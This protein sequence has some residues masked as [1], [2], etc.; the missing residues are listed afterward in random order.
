MTCERPLRPG[1]LTAGALIAVIAVMSAGACEPDPDPPPARPAELVAEGTTGRVTLDWADN[2]EEDLTRYEVSRATTSTGTYTVISPSSLTRSTFSDT[3]AP[4]GSIRYYRVVAIDDAGGRSAPAIANGTALGSSFAWGAGAVS[5]ID[6]YEG[7]GAVVG[8]EVLVFGGYYD[9]LFRATATA[10]AYDLATNSWRSLADV[11]ELITHAPA[12]VDG[13]SVWLLGGYV[14]DSPGGATASVWIYDVATDLWRPGPPL[15]ERRGAGAAA[16]VGREL[17]YFGGTDRTQ[18]TE[19]DIDRP[20]HWVLDLDL[21][22]AWTSRAP[23]PNPRNHL[24]AA[25][26]EGKVYA[27]GGQLRD[28][29]SDDNQDD[30]HVYDPATDAW[31]QVANLPRGRGHLMWSTI[32][33]DGHLVAAGGLVGAPVSAPATSSAVTAYDPADDVWFNLAPLPA[34]RK[35]PVFAEVGDRIVLT[36]GATNVPRGET[37]TGT[38]SVTW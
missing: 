6:H 16:V 38:L 27:V 20:D 12:V 4:V 5:P 8:S 28:H 31:A 29:R 14:G 18:D 34:T 19:D 32:A 35:S 17:H 15:P 11:P 22:V 13:N 9:D 30:V 26:L 37:W 10:H 23:L 3:G 33:I 1:R 7:S 21:P 2:S 24:G 36:Q 25:T